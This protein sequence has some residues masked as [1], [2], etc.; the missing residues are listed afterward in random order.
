[1]KLHLLFLLLF[2]QLVMAE[3]FDVSISNNRYTPND[4]TIQVGDTVRWTNTAGFHDVVA[5]DGSFSSG[6]PSSAAFVYERTFNTAAEILYHCSVHS[7]AGQNINTFMNGRINVLG[8]DPDPEPSFEINQGIS[9]A[10]Y[11]PDTSGSGI[12]FDIRPSDKFIFAAWF[13]YDVETPE[14][15]GSVDNRWFVVNGNYEG[16]MAENV[17]LFHTSGGIF[18]NPQ[19]VSSVQIGTMTFEFNDCNTGTASYIITDGSLTGSF[20]IQRVI[21][22][23]DSLCEALIPIEE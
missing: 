21:P 16:N 6:P 5:D 9:G 14:K 12:L 20:P 22:G 11:F 1:M 13:T 4:I 19:D 7:V 3:T 23:T 18:D 8:D 10:W 17:P 15:I 2:T